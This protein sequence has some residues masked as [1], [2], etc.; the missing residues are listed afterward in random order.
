MNTCTIYFVYLFIRLY[1]CL[2][3]RWL[4][5]TMSLLKWNL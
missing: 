3:W 4:C 2:F 5:I 1:R